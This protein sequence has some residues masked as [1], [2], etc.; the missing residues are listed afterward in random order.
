MSADVDQAKAVV[1]E[2]VVEPDAAMDRTAET[3][4]VGETRLLM[5]AAEQSGSD[6]CP[7]IAQQSAAAELDASCGRGTGAGG[8]LGFAAAWFD[9]LDAARAG[10]GAGD[11]GRSGGVDRPAGGRGCGF[12]GVDGAD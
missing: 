7:A 3:M 5:T 6:A 1:L 10:S 11:A 12:G 8:G 9:A 4:D 2:D